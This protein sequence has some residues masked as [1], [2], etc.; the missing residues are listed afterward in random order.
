MTRFTKTLAAGAAA[1]TLAAAFAP[2]AE[3]RFHRGGFLAAGLLGG[4]LLGSAIIANRAHAAPGYYAASGDCYTVRQ[5]VWDD[6]RGRFVFVR[7]TVC[8]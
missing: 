2:S 1:L 8:E 5:R 3:A 4:A 7:K 6:Y